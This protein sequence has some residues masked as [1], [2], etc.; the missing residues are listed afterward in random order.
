MEYYK[1]L[2]SDAYWKQKLVIKP[3][4]KDLLNPPDWLI[5]LKVLSR[6]NNKFFFTECNSTDEFCLYMNIRCTEFCNAA[7]ILVCATVIDKLSV[8]I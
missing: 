7:P 2:S 5:F 6:S 4:I 8:K 1:L 3:K